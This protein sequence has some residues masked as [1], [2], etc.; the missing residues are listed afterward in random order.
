MV[1]IVGFIYH[2]QILDEEA[3][4]IKK[5]GES[6]RIYMKQIPRYILFF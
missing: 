6:Y 1:I 4:C 2:I 5:Y 3:A